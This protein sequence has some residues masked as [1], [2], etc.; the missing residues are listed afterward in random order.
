MTSKRINLTEVECRSKKIECKSVIVHL[1]IDLTNIYNYQKPSF[2]HANKAF[3]LGRNVENNTLWN[4]NNQRVKCYFIACG[5]EYMKTST[6]MALTEYYKNYNKKDVNCNIHCWYCNHSIDKPCGIPVKLEG[7]KFHVKGFFC[8][9]NCALS[10]NYESNE[11]ENVIQ[12]REALIRMMHKTCIPAGGSLKYAPPKESLKI[13]GG[14]LSID[15][16]R[17]NNKYINV[18][19]PPVIPLVSYFEENAP[20]EH[21]SPT[22]MN[23]IANPKNNAIYFHTYQ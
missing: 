21:E 13:F 15:E 9:F 6:K 2:F 11:M 8:S 18:I 22:M 20:I 1:P 5:R 3:D 14:T 17:D 19:Y 4:A 23:G 7:N 12:E 16:F 10:Y